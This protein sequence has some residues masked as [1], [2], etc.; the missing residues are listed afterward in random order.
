MTSFHRP[1]NLGFKLCQEKKMLIV[2]NLQET[3][4]NII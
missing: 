2:Q 4:L 1:K 3:S